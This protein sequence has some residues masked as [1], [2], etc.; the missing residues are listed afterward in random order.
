M[1]ADFV[2]PGTLSV[3]VRVSSDDK[4]RF[5][6]QVVGLPEI[7]ATAT[8]RE[9]AVES[10]RS[11]VAAWIASGQLLP[12][13]VP[14]GNPLLLWAGWAKDDPDYD[15]FR[16]EI[17]RQREALDKAAEDAEAGPCSDTSSIPAT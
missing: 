3:L 17:R 2:P 8:R 11:T 15:D 12:L 9:E 6:A 13:D 1:A 4:G 7:Q 10:V 14:A 5:T 16:E